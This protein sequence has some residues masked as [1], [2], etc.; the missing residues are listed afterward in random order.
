MSLKLQAEQAPTILY[1]DVR[2][3]LRSGDI[4]A[5][6]HGS[7]DN[8]NNIKVIGVRMMTLSTYSHVGV[9]EYDPTDGHYYAIEAV[10]PKSHRIRLSSIGPFY[11]MRVP[12]TSW[13]EA[14]SAY[15][16][17]IL[18]TPYSE[19]KA[20]IAYFWKL[21]DGDVSECA[22]LCREIMKRASIDL[23]ESSRPDRVVQSALSQGAALTY[24]EKI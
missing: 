2:D 24:I 23:G 20:I 3:E 17:S 5:Q 18:G 9:I 22:A 10:K 19:W 8:W 13:S 1:R 4:Y 15:A 11:H 21:K 16:K 14:T 12:K 7:W 6:S